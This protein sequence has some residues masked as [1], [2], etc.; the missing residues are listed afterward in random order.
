MGVY[1]TWM[2]KLISG[3]VVRVNLPNYVIFSLLPSIVSWKLWDWKCKVRYE[4]NV[5]TVDSVRKVIKF[6]IRQIMQLIMKV[7]RISNQD[8]AIVNRLDIP[9]VLPKP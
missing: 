3:F 9:V 5:D 7:T 6:W 4:E 2:N 1:N 8:I